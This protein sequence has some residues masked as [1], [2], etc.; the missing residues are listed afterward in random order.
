V[1]VVVLAVD[2]EEVL[3]MALSEDEDPVE[4]LVSERT[5]PVFG[6]G[7]R[8]RRLDRRADHLMPLDRKISSK[9][10]EEFRVAVVHEKARIH[11]ASTRLLPTLRSERIAIG[12]L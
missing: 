12:P 9:A 2:A 7:V 10:R 8:V 6:V 4:T 1:G 5:Y 11:G 3:K